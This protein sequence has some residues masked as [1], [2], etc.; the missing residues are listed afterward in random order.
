MQLEEVATIVDEA[1]ELYD[2][3]R[4]LLQGAIE[5]IGQGIAVWINS[6]V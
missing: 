4:G 2:F 3:S 5:H 1:S 6:Y